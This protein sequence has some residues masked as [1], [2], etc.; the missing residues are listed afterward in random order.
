MI[1]CLRGCFLIVDMSCGPTDCLSSQPVTRLSESLLD[2]HIC[3]HG[4]L[5]EGLHE[6]AAKNHK[7]ALEAYRTVL[8]GNS[9]NVYA[10]NGIGAVLAEQAGPC[11]TWQHLAI[12][13]TSHSQG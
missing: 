3:V 2:S 6:R 8:E 4:T 9:S 7:Q 5:Q 11:F 1:W 10:A 13:H 12:G